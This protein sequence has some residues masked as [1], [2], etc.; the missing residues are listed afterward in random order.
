[1]KRFIAKYTINPAITQG[2]SECVRLIEKGKMADIVLWKPV[3]FGVKPEMIIKG[4]MI[5]A[6]RWET[7]MHLYQH[8]HL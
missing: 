1:V 6:S 8:R 5:I 3:L 7:L 2:I 4:G